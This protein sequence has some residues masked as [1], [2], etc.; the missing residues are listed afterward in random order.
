[1]RV[2]VISLP[3]CTERRENIDRQMKD[4]G[5]DY[6]FFDAVDG[7]KEEHKAF[8]QY[9]ELRTLKCFGGPLAVAEYACYASHYKVWEQCAE[10]DEPFLIMEDDIVCDEN[11]PKSCEL[12]LSKLDD[13]DCVRIS[14][15]SER[16]CKKVEDLGDGFTLARYLRGPSGMQAYFVSPNGAAALIKHAEF[17]VEPVDR[18]MD[19]FWVHGMGHYVIFPHTVRSGDFGTEIGARK[20][21]RSKYRIPAKIRRVGDHVARWFYNLRVDD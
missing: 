15:I 8:R 2:V 11:F 1:M 9:D 10:S 14:G 21:I 20:R 3:R 19:R 13:L 17:W 6:E 4:A 5:F 18:Y 12:A 16:P 7:S